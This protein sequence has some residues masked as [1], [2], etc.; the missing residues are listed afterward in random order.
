MRVHGLCLEV[1]CRNPV[2]PAL[3][4][5]RTGGGRKRTN[6]R[7]IG[8]D[9]A[10]CRYTQRQELPIGIQCQLH[11]ADLSAS[12]I[13]CR[14]AF[15]ALADPLDRATQ[16]LCSEQHQCVF[17]VKAVSSAEA[18]ADVKG[19][20]AQLRRGYVEHFF[21]QLVAVGVNILCV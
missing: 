20:M 15:A 21:R 17:G 7:H 11:V 13:V 16:A 9:I 12:M 18:A 14:K 1:D 4:P 5:H 19:H 6:G 8:A 2:E 10:G 3:G